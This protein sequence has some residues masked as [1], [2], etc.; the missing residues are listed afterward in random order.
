MFVFIIFALLNK[1]G[2]LYIIIMKII[3]I[4]GLLGVLILFKHIYILHNFDKFNFVFFCIV[5]N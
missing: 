5:F 1:G 3:I 2:W 4:Y